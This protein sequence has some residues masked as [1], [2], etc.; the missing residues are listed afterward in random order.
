MRVT[1]VAESRNRLRYVLLLVLLATLMIAVAPADAQTLLP[2]LETPSPQRHCFGYSL[3]AG[4]ALL[5]IVGVA[6]RR[7]GRSRG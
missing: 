7:R 6:A 3:A 5:I 1:A 2:T 4:G